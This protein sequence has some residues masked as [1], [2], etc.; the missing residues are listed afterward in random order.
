MSVL[1]TSA[2]FSFLALCWTIAF[3]F[4]ATALLLCLAIVIRRV[5]RNRLFAKRKIQQA[6]FQNYISQQLK[7]NLAEQPT[8]NVPPCHIDDI[9]TVLLHYFRTLKGRQYNQL[10]DLIS[11]SKI[12]ADITR[13]SS[14]GVRGARMRAVRVLSHLH[15]QTSTQVIFDNLV[16]EDKYVRLTA[17]KSLVQR[18]STFFLTDIINS[19]NDAFPDDVQLLAGIIFDFGTDIVAPL[20]DYIKMS[21]NATARAACLEALSQ[22]MPPQTSLN[23]GAL[24]G[25][26]SELVRTATLSLAMITRSPDGLDPLRMGLQDKAISVKIRAA[27]LA[28]DQRRSDVTS[29]LYALTNSPEMWVRYW[30]LRAIWTT[31]TSGQQF[32]ET[33]RKTNPL[34]TDVAL[35]MRSGYV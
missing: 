14:S 15:S 25:D 19:I 9:T 7:Q 12:E 17:A 13:S 10:Q 23:L 28:C 27:K 2:D 26:P 18:G 29:E 35:E 8:E 30:A 31:G 22:I 34:A 5:R 16:S 21:N 6:A 32:V 4:F 33:L 24:M 11:G 20:E 3:V 1:P